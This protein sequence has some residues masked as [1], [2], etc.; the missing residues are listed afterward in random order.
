MKNVE[1]FVFNC[2]FRMRQIECSGLKYTF[3]DLQINLGSKLAYE[4]VMTTGYYK[5][6]RLNI[7]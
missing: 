5:R 7:F 4:L 2:F 6:K 1:N 3:R